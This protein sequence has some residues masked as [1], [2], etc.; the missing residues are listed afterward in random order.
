MANLTTTG[1]LAGLMTAAIFTLGSLTPATAA[2]VADPAPVPA[3]VAETQLAQGY[4]T[5]GPQ[6][7]QGRWQRPPQNQ[8]QFQFNWP[9]GHAWIAPGWQPPRWQPPQWQPPR[10]QPP[11]YVQPGWNDPRGGHNNR[12]TEWQVRGVLNRQGWD[13]IRIVR[14]DTWT[15]TVRAEDRWNRDRVLTVNAYTGVVLSVRNG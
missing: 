1:R 6:P 14:S 3:P 12:L 13:D 8:Y 2:G 5:P 9:G 10:W 4:W 7:Q 15:Y 11:R